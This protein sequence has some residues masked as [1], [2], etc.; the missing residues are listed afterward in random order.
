MPV[1]LIAVCSLISGCASPPPEP[2]ATKR[3]HEQITEDEWA[4][5]VRVVDHLPDRRLPSF[6]AIFPPPPQWQEGRTA[7]VSDLCREEVRRREECW[8]PARLAPV[9]ARHKL[10]MRLLQREQ[11]TA[12]QFAGLLL[13]IGAANCRSSVPPTLDLAAIADRAQKEVDELN[14]NYQQAFTLLSPETRYAVIV[15]AMWIPR[16]IRIQKLQQAPEENIALVK[17]NRAWLDKAF[18]EELLKNP[19]EELQDLFEERGMPFEER[20]ESGSDE[21]L[22]SQLSLSSPLAR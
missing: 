1:C 19:P 6:P 20:P 16:M 12:E 14:R 7:L 3:L 2:G 21:D 5:F 11:L 10:L 22:A 8:D 15:Q 17:R 4:A 13:A 18:P 9:F